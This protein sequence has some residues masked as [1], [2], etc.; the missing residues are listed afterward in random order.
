MRISDD[1]MLSMRRAV[2]GAVVAVGASVA[3]VTVVHADDE[4]Q[5]ASTTASIDVTTT[6]D[7]TTTEATTA[8]PPP[9]DVDDCPGCG[10]G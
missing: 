3:L 1:A 6:V 2:A 8:P 4:G 5:G 10:L 9:L 7:V